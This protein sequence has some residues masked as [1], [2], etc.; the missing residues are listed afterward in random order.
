MDVDKRTQRSKKVSKKKYSGMER[1][2]QY[3]INEKEKTM[4]N[5]SEQM[6]KQLHPIK[7]STDI[8]PD[9]TK[10]TQIFESQWNFNVVTSMADEYF[11]SLLSIN[12]ENTRNITFEI[13]QNMTFKLITYNEKCILFDILDKKTVLVVYHSD[14][15]YISSVD[16]S[17]NISSVSILNNVFPISRLDDLKFDNASGKW[18][19]EADQPQYLKLSKKLGRASSKWGYL[20]PQI[21]LQCNGQKWNLSQGEWRSYIDS[22]FTP[23]SENSA[24]IEDKKKVKRTITK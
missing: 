24:V 16:T 5:S 1:R 8:N 2:E 21:N 19:H 15:I 14:K 11:C 3:K 18:Y 4:Q 9:L 7:P 22:V 10:I 13:P 17:S 6:A 20:P 12:R 23:F